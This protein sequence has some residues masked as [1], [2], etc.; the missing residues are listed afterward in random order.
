MLRNPRMSFVIFV[1]VSSFLLQ[2]LIAAESS[3]DPRLVREI[4]SNTPYLLIDDY[5]IENRFNE[6]QISARVPH[7]LQQGERL[8][9]PVMTYDP[10]LAWEE[11]GVGY[12]SI[13]FDTKAQKFRLYYQIWNPRQKKGQ[14]PRGGY[15]TC[16]AE[17]DDGIHWVRPLLELESY[18]EIQKTNILMSGE[19]EAKAGHVMPLVE[20]GTTKHGVP[21]KNLGMLPKVM[22]RGHQFVMLYCDNKHYLATSE[23]GLRWQ[24]RQSKLLPNR[25]DCFQ[26]IVYDPQYDE[27][28]VFYR[29]KLINSDKPH[30]YPGR[31]NTRYISRIAGKDPWTLWDHMPVPVMIPDGEDDG[32]FYNMTV[33]RYGD[34]YL[35]F[36]S[37]FAEEPQRID[38]E[39]VYSRDGF[40]W[41]RLPGSRKIIPC[42][43]EGTWDS[44]MTF[45]ADRILEVGDQ[46]WLYYTGHNGYHDSLKRKG[47][48][49]LVKFGK[50]RLVAIQADRRG[51]QSFVVTRPMVW[52]GGDL[53]INANAEEGS[54]RVAVSDLYR[55][56]IQGFA[57]D[58]SLSLTEDQIR[59]YVQWRERKMDSLKGK[60]V[61]LE[62]W[63]ENAN[64]YSFLAED[65]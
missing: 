64:L 45:S 41:K 38:V 42:G 35:G 7:V 18:G 55:K 52:P 21:V 30:E 19:N 62:F 46:W 1:L 47:A 57:F 51:K 20:S 54:L 61:R 32:R 36:L 48:L 4:Q 65:K 23:D 13:V 49:G 56:P 53:V 39:L 25:V 43:A 26:S 60:L 12:S 27:Y 6:D 15:R 50:E 59:H 11:H 10:N 40:D 8:A 17:S 24:Q 37:Q 34:V 33:M 2:V 22:H 9:E 5:F 31:G 44:G 16:F 28:A 14:K 63:F 58:E 29:N 3:F